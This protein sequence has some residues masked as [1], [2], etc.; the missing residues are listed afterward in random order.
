MTLQE[1]IDAL[2]RPRVEVFPFR[3]VAA[4]VAACRAW[5][6]ANPEG[7][8]RYRALIAQLEAEAKAA[9]A[10]EA[11]RDRVERSL[12]RANQS[13]AIRIERSG[14]GAR[15]LEAT[16]KL[17]ETEALATTKRWLAQSEDLTLVLCGVPGAGKTVAATW[18]VREALRRGDGAAFRS[19]Q[20]LAKL[21]QFDVGAAEMEALKH[22]DLLSISDFGTELLGDYAKAQLFEL[23]DWR[24]ENYGRTVITAN[25]PWAGATSVSARLGE[26][27]SDRIK[28]TGKI[29]QLAAVKSLRERK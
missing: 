25:L 15:S 4:S 14:I 9:E 10:A 28:Q 11:E 22:V 27:L 7:A 16:E 2:G 1:Q 8:S 19:A 13:L 3:A 24:H 23:L 21:S 12:R 17:F 18:A 6:E 5:D 29:V 20:S 26:R